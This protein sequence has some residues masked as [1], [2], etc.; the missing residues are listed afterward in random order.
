MI[1]NSNH[2]FTDSAILYISEYLRKVIESIPKPDS[3][4][5]HKIIH[6]LNA[7]YAMENGLKTLIWNSSKICL[8]M[9]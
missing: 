7:K 5:P 1:D 8:T 2:E 6:N 9:F 4:Q 3:P